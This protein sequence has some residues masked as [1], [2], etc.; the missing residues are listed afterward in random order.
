[1]AEIKTVIVNRCNSC[2]SA[3]H[4]VVGTG[5]DFEYHTCDNEFTFVRCNDCGL[6][7]LKNRPEVGELGSIYPEEYIP[8][9]F[10]EHL[11]GLITNLRNGVQAKKVKALAKFLPDD[12]IVVDVGPG[13]GEFLRLIQKFGRPGWDLWGIDFSPEACKHL[14]KLGFGAVQSRFED[15]A[16]SI[17]PPHVITMNQVIEHLEDPARAIEKA[18]SMLRPGGYLF[19]ET[20]NTWAWDYTLFKGRYWGGWHIPRHWVLFDEKTLGRTLV[21]KGFE[22]TETNYLLSP[23]FWLQSFHHY[24][25]EKKGWPNAAKLFDVSVLPF[26]VI[27]SSIDV[28][29]R[30][31]TGRTSNLRMIAKKPG[32]ADSAKHK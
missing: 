31:M 4:S 7:W 2:G 17:D 24:F 10:N 19:L 1:M 18:Y 27:A 12:A 14:E 23:N 9:N 20:P 8:H 28:I 30:L 29:Q 13:N 16:W 3:S 11:G 21:G 22:V 32:A 26:L 5:T 6:I 15:A 25:A